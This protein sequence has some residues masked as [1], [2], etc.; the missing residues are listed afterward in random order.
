M[1]SPRNHRILLFD[2]GFRVAGEDGTS[3]F[4]GGE[5]HT[6]CTKANKSEVSSPH[7]CTSGQAQFQ[8]NMSSVSTSSGRV[9][10]HG[11]DRRYRSSAGKKSSSPQEDMSLRKSFAD[12]MLF[13]NEDLDTLEDLKNVQAPSSLDTAMMN[14]VSTLPS[15]GGGDISDDPAMSQR[16]LS[17]SVSTRRFNEWDS[18]LSHRNFED[19]SA[20]DRA[21]REV[22]G[23]TLA[24]FTVTDP[25][26]KIGGVLP[27]QD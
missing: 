7:Y 9:R 10:A 15:S 19:L 20:L 5:H 12:S 4:S 14:S 13:D 27:R 21:N 3:L 18:T 8:I 26:S 6:A 1:T 16:H 23:R 24:S 25:L 11:T 17:S 2:F 22:A